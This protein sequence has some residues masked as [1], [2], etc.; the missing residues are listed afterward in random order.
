MFARANVI[1]T[2]VFLE[3]SK[4]AYHVQHAIVYV[5]QGSAQNYFSGGHYDFR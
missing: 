1:A 4:C 2:G 5:A 3:Q